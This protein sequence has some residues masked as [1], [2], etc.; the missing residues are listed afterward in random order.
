MIITNRDRKLQ[1]ETF[2]NPSSDRVLLIAPAMGVSHKFYRKI[3]DYFYKKNY[4]V[5]TFGYFGMFHNQRT[6]NL[7]DLQITDWGRKDINAVMEYAM[8]NFPGQDYFFL[9]H[10]IAGQVLPLA[11]KS[12]V[13]TAAFLVA[14]QNA[15]NQ[16]WDGSWKIRVLFF[17]Y[18][19][20]PLFS[21]LLG[22]IP[23]FAYGGKYNLNKFIAKN[24]AVWGK[25]K[26]GLLGM[27]SDYNIFNVPT[28]FIS[29]TDDSLLAPPRAV[30]AIYNAYGSDYK[31]HE[32]IKPKEVGF[33]SIGHFNFFRDDYSILWTKTTRWYDLIHNHSKAV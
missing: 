11:E 4:S 2:I 30:K 31:V 16:Y 32:H 29:F 8:Q 24:W 18:F 25:N 13:L 14:S 26:A 23:G 27:E 17:W 5:I 10:S 21:T 22:Y 7:K 19:I 1:G 9:G 15:S 20:I 33:T 12:R 6:K 3:A 28:K